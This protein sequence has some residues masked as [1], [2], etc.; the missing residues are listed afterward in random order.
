MIISK[1]TLDRQGLAYRGY[2]DKEYNYSDQIVLLLSLWHSPVIKNGW[3][4]KQSGIINPTIILI[5][6]PKTT[7]LLADN[8]K[9]LL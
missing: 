6:I 4:K 8:V 3:T 2:R 5:I 9:K 7:K 1:P